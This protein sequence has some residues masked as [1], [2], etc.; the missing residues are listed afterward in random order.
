MYVVFQCLCIYYVLKSV[1]QHNKGGMLECICISVV[2]IC[3]YVYK[4]GCIFSL[5]YLI[6]QLAPTVEEEP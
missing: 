2:F 4:D 6:S 1:I 5:V 3:L